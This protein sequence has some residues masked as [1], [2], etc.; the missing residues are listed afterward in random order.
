MW[1]EG[2][3]WMY[4][5]ESRS[6]AASRAEWR[7]PFRWIPFTRVSMQRVGVLLA[8][9]GAASESRVQT[10][11]GLSNAY[12]RLL[13][14]KIAVPDDSQGMFGDYVRRQRLWERYGQASVNRVLEQADLQDLWLADEQVPSSTG[15]ITEKV[16]HE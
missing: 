1:S 13:T 4:V 10:L 6:T 14:R 15:A 7:M 16:A 11:E 8:V 2:S 5:R 3:S 9:V 12:S